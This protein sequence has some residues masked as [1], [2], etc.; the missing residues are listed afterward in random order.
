MRSVGVSPAVSAGPRSTSGRATVDAARRWRHW[1]G[2][3]AV[4]AACLAG[5]ILVRVEEGLH[6]WIEST[7]TYVE[8]GTRAKQ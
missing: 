6:H 3:A 8:F 1:G 7:L 2:F 5:E 4:A